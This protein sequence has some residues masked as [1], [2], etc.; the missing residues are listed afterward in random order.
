MRSLLARNDELIEAL[1]PRAL[2]AKNKHIIA[3]YSAA[4]S[5]RA[6]LLALRPPNEAVIHHVLAEATIEHR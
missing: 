5:R 6:T 4:M 2:E 3:A 1:R